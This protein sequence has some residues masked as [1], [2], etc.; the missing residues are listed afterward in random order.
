MNPPAIDQRS[1]VAARDQDRIDEAEARA[2]IEVLVEIL[3]AASDRSDEEFH[4]RAGRSPGFRSNNLT[5]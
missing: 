2:K 4:E 1:P 3:Q 5:Q